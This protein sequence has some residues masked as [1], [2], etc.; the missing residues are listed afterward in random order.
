MPRLV[1]IIT[2][3]ELA[4]A[5]DLLVDLTS[6]SDEELQKISPEEL[7]VRMGPVRTLGEQTFHRTAA[8]YEV[9]ARER[10]GILLDRLEAF[11]EVQ[12]WRKL[13]RDAR[14]RPS[15]CYA[16]Y[17]CFLNLIVS[18]SSISYHV[19]YSVIFSVEEELLISCGIKKC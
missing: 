19:G 11:Y 12:E 3:S 16:C 5:I 18:G 17:L 2:D 6:L 15:A 10:R 7:L 4:N 8:A 14:R 1:G 9:S 13:R